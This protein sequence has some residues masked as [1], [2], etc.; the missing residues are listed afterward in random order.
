LTNKNVTAAK[1][2]ER[3]IGEQLAKVKV[4]SA[5]LITFHAETDVRRGGSIVCFLNFWHG[6]E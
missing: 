4:V 6:D 3:D 1:E 2:A 5:C